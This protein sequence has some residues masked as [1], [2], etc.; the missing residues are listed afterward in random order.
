MP[1]L[2]WF[3]KSEGFKLIFIV[4]GSRV[5]GFLVFSKLFVNL[6]LD[7][8]TFIFFILFLT[9]KTDFW[10]RIY[11]CIQRRRKVLIYN[12]VTGHVKGQI[13]LSK[14]KG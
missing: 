11:E 9:T 8:S 6:E 3:W 13:I 10:F 4:H 2:C 12:L 14:G 5:G 7:C 1:R